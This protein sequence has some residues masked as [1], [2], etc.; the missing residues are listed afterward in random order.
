M[1]KSICLETIFTEVDFYDRF[2]LA[3]KYGFKYVEFWTHHDKDIAKIKSLLEKYSLE[4]AS[5]TGDYRYSLIDIK[6][7]D[8]Y[9]KDIK[10]ALKVAKFLSCKNIVIHSNAL[11]EE[12][13]VINHYKDL[14]EKEKTNAM[15]ETLNILKDEAKKSEICL[16]LEALNI[17]CD[18]KGNAL[19]YTKDT[20][21]II[22][23][24][25]CDFIKVLYDMYHMQINEGN[26]ISTLKQ[27]KNEIAYIHIADAP[28]RKE[29][30]TGEINFSNVSK[31]LR[32][33]YTDIP[34]G[35][36]LF[37]KINSQIAVKEIINL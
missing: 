1:K 4:L 20:A 12:G 19:K 8:V 23:E 32:E 34:I 30:G 9:I 11:G 22:K 27:Y 33:L 15:I 17:H 37:P 18:H 36:E 14:S 29:P 3:Y 24:V 31:I 26:I 35:F 2:S 16:V 10:E 5:F 28:G 21:H 6:K 25:S 13:V 7:Q